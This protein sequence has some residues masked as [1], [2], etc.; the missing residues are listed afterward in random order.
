M[1]E[2][3][4]QTVEKIETNFKK[5]DIKKAQIKQDLFVKAVYTE[6]HG[7]ES[8]D[9]DRTSNMPIHD[10]LREA[11]KDVDP[12]MEKICEQGKDS[13]VRCTGIAIG[14]DGEGVTLIGHRE[15]KEGGQLN[16]VSPHISFSG[17]YCL[18]PKG[19]DFRQS[20]ARIEAEVHEYLFNEKYAPKTQLTMDFV[21][22]LDNDIKEF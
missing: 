21:P 15:L 20:I 5:V 1:S 13:G 6:Q 10:D 8:N 3:T 22:G 11:F 19:K 4:E 9:Y 16:L 7:E 2:K 12:H 17:D 14:K 18:S